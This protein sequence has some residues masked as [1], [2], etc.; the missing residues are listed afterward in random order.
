MVAS[1]KVK[2]VS[3][4]QGDRL[5]GWRTETVSEQI[6]SFPDIHKV[7][8]LMAWQKN[9]A[10]SNEKMLS[11]DHFRTVTLNERHCCPLN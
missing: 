2:D 6:L 8:G 9:P 7:S 4:L 5:M 10:F 3:S 11:H 1:G